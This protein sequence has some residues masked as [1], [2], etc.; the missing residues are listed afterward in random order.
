MRRPRRRRGSPESNHLSISATDTEWEEV[1]RKADLRGLPMARYLVGLAGRDGGEDEPVMALAE[2][3]QRELL[4]AVR[5]IR[6]LVQEGG[7]TAP[8]MHDMQERA[9]V[10]FAAWLRAM[11]RSGRRSGLLD[12]LAAVL[13]EDRARIVALSLAADTPAAAPAPSAKD[14]QNRLL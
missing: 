5:D 13:G 2:G 7:D 10:Q 14:G 12:A 1:R 3:E 6:S 9:A 11:V 4:A 8:L